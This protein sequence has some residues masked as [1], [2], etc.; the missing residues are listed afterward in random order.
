M[1]RYQLPKRQALRPLGCRPHGRR[2]RTGQ[3]V[4]SS[5]MELRPDREAPFPPCLYPSGTGD[6]SIR[7]PC[8][9]LDFKR[10]LTVTAF[11]LA[12]E[13]TDWGVRAACGD[14]AGGVFHPVGDGRRQLPDA[15]GHPRRYR[16]R[17]DSGRVDRLAGDLSAFL[18]WR[19]RS[20]RSPREPAR[21]RGTPTSRPQRLPRRPPVRLAETPS[22]REV[23]TVQIVQSITRGIE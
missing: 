19:R 23:S 17:A 8:A 3:T 15:I 13:A 10:W 1:L 7:G 9:L 22:R 2:G 4:T 5:T 21:P 6:S 16:T 11:R 14:F 18:A 20:T 12:G